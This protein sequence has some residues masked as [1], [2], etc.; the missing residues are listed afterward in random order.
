MN[1]EYDPSI[2]GT[3]GPIKITLANKIYMTA[4]KLISAAGQVAGFQY[5]QD[6]NGV[7]QLGIS[8]SQ[9]NQGVSANDCLVLS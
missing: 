1:T 8:W 4:Q 6:P 9:M 5:N 3:N 2:H 7:N